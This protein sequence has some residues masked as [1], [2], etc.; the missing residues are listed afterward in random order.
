MYSTTPKIQSGYADPQIQSLLA[1]VEPTKH[2]SQP[3]GSKRVP[4][5]LHFRSGQGVGS[6][7]LFTS[8]IPSHQQCKPYMDGSK[9]LM[10]TCKNVPDGNVRDGNDDT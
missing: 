4:L 2:H 1:A 10:A 5:Q 3:A 6:L 8:Q 7:A 9:V